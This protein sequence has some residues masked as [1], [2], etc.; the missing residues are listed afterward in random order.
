MGSRAFS[1]HLSC[2]GDEVLGI[3]VVDLNLESLE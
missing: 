3:E 2:G 1:A